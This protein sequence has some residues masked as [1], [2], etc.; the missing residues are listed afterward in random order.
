MASELE[1]GSSATPQS[2][3]FSAEF[4]KAILDDL[5]QD[6][7]R[8]LNRAFEI[9]QASF[10]KTIAE[11]LQELQGANSP[12][13]SSSEFGKD[14][15]WLAIESLSSLR[16][17]VGGRFNNLKQKW[18][19]AGFPL[20]EHRGDKGKGFQVDQ[21]GWIELSNWILKQGFEAR[22][23]PDKPECLFELRKVG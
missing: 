12:A 7:E 22:L 21:K 5:M 14:S 17:L 18:V 10:V 16:H 8:A 13:N 23:T 9:R 1:Q 19:D 20:R 4:Q 2:S 15:N 6:C 11:R 3:K